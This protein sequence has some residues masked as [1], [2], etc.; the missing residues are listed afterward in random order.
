MLTN[1]TWVQIIVTIMHRVPTQLEVLIVLVI[2]DSLE[3]ELIVRV[4]FFFFFFFDDIN[5]K[6]K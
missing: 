2:Q 6:L 3:M 1:V 4:E 5:I